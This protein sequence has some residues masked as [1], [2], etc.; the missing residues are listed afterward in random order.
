LRKVCGRVV[1]CHTP[2]ILRAS[3]GVKYF[4]SEE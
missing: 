3:G 2:F 4:F 1:W